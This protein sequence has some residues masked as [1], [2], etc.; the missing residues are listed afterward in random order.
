MTTILHKV[1]VLDHVE[2][3]TLDYFIRKKLRVLNPFSRAEYCRILTH[4][5]SLNAEKYCY[6]II[7]FLR[8]LENLTV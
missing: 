2:I 5:W 3:S 1:H 4:R 6:D 8:D 7:A